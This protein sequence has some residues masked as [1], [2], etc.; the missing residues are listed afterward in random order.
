MHAHVQQFHFSSGCFGVTTRMQ[1]GQTKNLHLHEI[2][3][4]SC[5]MYGELLALQ[6][7]KP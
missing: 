7:G 1:K 2:E 5:C 3:Y 6:G 4:N